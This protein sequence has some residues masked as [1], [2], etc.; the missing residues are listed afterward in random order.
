MRTRRKTEAP[1]PEFASSRRPAYTITK[2]CQRYLGTWYPS[3]DSPQV[4]GG[5]VDYREKRKEKEKE[6]GMA[7]S[8]I[9]TQLSRADLSLE[10]SRSEKVQTSHVVAISNFVVNP[11]DPGSRRYL[12]S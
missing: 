11:A 2:V 6:K 10:R 8:K 7:P 3:F 12:F 5:W 1:R 9:E 4:R